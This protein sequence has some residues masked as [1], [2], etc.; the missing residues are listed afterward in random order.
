MTDVGVSVPSKAGAP[1]P[2][3]VPRTLAEPA[4]RTLG[5][6]DQLGLWG[7]LG[8]S[9]LGITGAMVV[10]QPAGAGSARLSLP[11]ALTATTLGTALGTAAVAATA[12]L[13]A[14]TG[15][16]T[17]VLLRGLFGARGSA[18]PTVLNMVQMIGW[19]TFEIV[20]IATALHQVVPGP[21]RWLWVVG[22][23]AATTAL[24]IRPLGS[25]RLLRRYVGVAVVVA[26]GWLLGQLLAGAP[27]TPGGGWTGF[28]SAVDATL[29]VAVSWV[30]MAADYARHS[31]TTR[32]ATTAAF[33]GYGVMQ[34]A[35]YALG[36]VALCSVATRH[37]DVFATFAALP[38]GLLATGVL[39]TRELDQSFADVYSTTVSTQNLRPR[40]DRRVISVVVGV[41]TTVVALTTDIDAYGSFLALIGSVFV[42]LFAV[43]VVDWYGFDGRRRWDLSHDGRARWP[44]LLPWLAGFAAYQLLAPGQVPGWSALWDGLA[45]AVDL[46]RPA[47][48]SASLV[49][50]AVAA[51]LTAAVHGA[52]RLAGG[53]A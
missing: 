29:A 30:P 40:W 2:T 46:G 45:R 16:P 37:G 52:A 53:R 6:L 49:S 14:R 47:W 1:T 42:P 38:L 7:N 48:A 31:R 15:A 51:A 32:A 12:A 3:E 41:V 22:C 13:G 20:T 23:G 9:L 35:C 5:L 24:A 4:P 26:L 39:V 34:I 8:V 19:G 33:V 18:A 10:L 43:L 36:L 21:P 11:A 25:V 28:G 17:M 50:F 44:M 27:P